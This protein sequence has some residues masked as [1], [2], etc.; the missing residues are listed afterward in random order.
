MK[1]HWWKTAEAEADEA[2]E[3]FT[4]KLRS[5]LAESPEKIIKRKNPF[6]FRIRVVNDVHELANMVTDA[7]LSSSEETMFGNVLEDITLAVCK[8]AKNGRKSGIANIDLEYDQDNIRTII[9]V[10]SGTNWGNSSQHKALRTAFDNAVRVLRQGRTRMAV[11]C[12]EGICYGKS[13]I[14]DKGAYQRIVGY[15]FWEDISD[16]EGTAKGVMNL[17]GRHAGNGLY[18]IR[19]EARDRMVEFLRDSNAVSPDGGVRWDAL[20][21]IVMRE[22]A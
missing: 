12:I 14:K 3:G 17:L 11:R 5:K 10:K 13:E 20:L 18:E 6:L 1:P 4:L 9:Q 21:D 16:W 7:Y 8:H 2:I 19:E 22:K 15:R